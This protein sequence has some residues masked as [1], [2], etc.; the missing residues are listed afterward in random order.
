MAGGPATPAPRGAAACRIGAVL[1]GRPAAEESALERFGT[2]LGIAFQLA[3]DALDYVASEV[4]LGKTVGDD[5]REGKITLPV[6]AAFDAAPDDAS[7]EFW[8]RTVERS[9]QHPEDLDHA[10]RLIRE[11]GAI[12]LT[13]R[14][15]GEFAA[16]AKSAL[17]VFAPSELR[18]LLGAV[19]DYAVTRLH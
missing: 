1:A 16:R 3:D 15:A 7:R 18:D 6:L 13:L 5:F 12:E 14:R 19:A 9:E 2:D 17:D 8:Q 4:E 10:R 11:A